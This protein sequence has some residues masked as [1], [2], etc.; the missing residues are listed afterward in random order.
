LGYAPRVTLAE[1]IEE[2]VEWLAGQIADDRSDM[3]SAELIE[4]GLM[5]STTSN[6]GQKLGA[7]RYT[8]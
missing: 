5:V 7:R 2:M 3:A 1:G 4:R 6:Y 8:W